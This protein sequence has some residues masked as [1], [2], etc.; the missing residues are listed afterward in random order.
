MAG[1]PVL[2]ALLFFAS[3]GL[4]EEGTKSEPL[5]RAV[6]LAVAAEYRPALQ[7]LE[8]LLREKRDDPLLNYY[9]GL[10]HW[11]LKDSDLSLAYLRR[12][13]EKEAPFP[14]AY[15]WLAQAHLAR[16]EEDPARETV[17][18]GLQLFPRNEKLKGLAARWEGRL[19]ET[20]AEAHSGPEP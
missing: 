7:I 9:A 1:C 17:K 16:G 8:T 3:L 12:A 20:P 4:E 10:C 13:V 5:R 18:R 2:A 19:L 6:S 14:Q 15:Y 11:Y